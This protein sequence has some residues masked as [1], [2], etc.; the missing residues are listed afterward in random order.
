M[1]VIEIVQ[2]AIRIQSMF[3]LLERKQNN[4]RMF[5]IQKFVVLFQQVKQLFLS[6]FVW[7]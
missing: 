4:K 6:I 3:E 2:I 7:F 1:N 5:W